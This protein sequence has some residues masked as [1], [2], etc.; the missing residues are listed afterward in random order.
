[1]IHAGGP[2][3]PGSMASIAWSTDSA[4]QVR[5][6]KT[7]CSPPLQ[8]QR[9][10]QCFFNLSMAWVSAMSAKYLPE[11][12]ETVREIRDH[13]SSQRVL[14]EEQVKRSRQAAE[15]SIALQRQALDRQRSVTVLAG[16]GILAC[17]TAIGYLVLKYL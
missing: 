11:L 6:A 4:G 1:M 15:E 17:I 7:A 13:L 9:A 16:T 10:R 14:F 12:L 3:T 8:R 5:R 2:L